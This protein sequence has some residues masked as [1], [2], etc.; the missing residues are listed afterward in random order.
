[1]T[2]PSTHMISC[3]KG[4]ILKPPCDLFQS[5]RSNAITHL[6]CQSALDVSSHR[7]IHLLHRVEVVEVG[8]EY[9]RR[10]RLHHEWTLCRSNHA[11]RTHFWCMVY[12]IARQSVYRTHCHRLRISGLILRLKKVHMKHDIYRPCTVWQC[13]VDYFSDP[14]PNLILFR[15][16]LPDPYSTAWI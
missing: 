15:W 16:T 3:K 1:M 6:F 7:L 9:P 13:L 8:K 2:F 4:S 11:Y 12:L 5:E 14:P 10:S